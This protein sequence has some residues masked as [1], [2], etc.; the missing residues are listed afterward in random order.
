MRSPLPRSRSA[1]FPS[2][3]HQNSSRLILI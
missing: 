1:P 3:L 2:C